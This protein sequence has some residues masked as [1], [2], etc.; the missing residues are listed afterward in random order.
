MKL[1]AYAEKLGISY[2]TAWRW[3][4]EGKLDAYQT[5]TG[6][7]IVGEQID[8][9]AVIALYARVSS[10]DQKD[11]LARQL[12]RLQTY[13]IA[14]GDT[15]SRIVTEVASGLNE[16]TSPPSPPCPPECTGAAAT[17]SGQNAFVSVSSRQRSMK[18]AYKS[19]LDPNNKQ[20]TAMRQ[21]VGAA[22]WAYN[23]GL[24]RIKQTA[25][26]GERWPS[27]VDLHQGHVQEPPSSACAQRRSA[28][29]VWAHSH[30]HGR[31]GRH[32]RPQGRAFFASSKTCLWM[33]ERTLGI[34]RSSVRV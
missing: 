16:S 4:K 25:A 7:I 13:A 6:T 20:I 9:P 34:V 5:E 24:E 19:E 30:L 12:E 11:D 22:R 15:V 23:W 32:H 2:K 18:S 33:E 3:W 17:S 8:A 31:G 28:W 1:S 29:T 10:A 21:H 27:A 26:N 14:K